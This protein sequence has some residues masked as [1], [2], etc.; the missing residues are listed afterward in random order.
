[1]GLIKNSEREVRSSLPCSYAIHPSLAHFA[2]HD[3]DAAGQVYRIVRDNRHKLIKHK[4]VCR[5][6]K[7]RSSWLKSDREKRDAFVF[8]ILCNDNDIISMNN[9]KTPFL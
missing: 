4:H 6:S 9:A 8:F 2:G 7:F 5:E 1:M 3:S